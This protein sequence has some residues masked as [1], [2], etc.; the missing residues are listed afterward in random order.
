MNN[1]QLSAWFAGLFLSGLCA[2]TEPIFRLDFDSDARF[3][4][5]EKKIE[6]PESGYVK[7]KS[8]RG[9]FFERA[10]RNILPEKTAVPADPAAFRPG[11]DSRLSIRDGILFLHGKKVTVPAFKTMMRQELFY[12]TTALTASCEV[13]GAKGEQ[14]TLSVKFHPWNLPEKQKQKIR[15]K[16][17]KKH[18][19][20]ADNSVP[21]TFVMTGDWQKIAAFAELDSRTVEGRYAV[22]ELNRNGGGEPLQ[23]RN[24][25]AE[26]TMFYPHKTY[27][28]TSFLPGKTVRPPA[29]SG[30]VLSDS[31]LQQHFPMEKGTVMFWIFLPSDNR[32][33]RN[34][35]AFFGFARGW[36]YPMW[37]LRSNGGTTGLKTGVFLKKGFP[38]NRWVHAALVW[39]QNQSYLYL[40][41]KPAISSPRKKFPKSNPDKYQLTIGRTQ[42]PHECADA[43]LD[44]FMIFDQAL[45]ESEIAAF[46]SERIQKPTSSHRFKVKPFSVPPFFRD[47]PKAGILLTVES[48]KNCRITAEITSFETARHVFQ[49]NKGTNEI[50]LPFHPARMSPGKGKLKIILRGPEGIFLVYH[51]SYEIHPAVRRDLMRVLSWGGYRPVPLHYLK[52]LGINAV[53]TTPEKELEEATRLGMLVNLDFRNH[54]EMVQ[55]NFDL[56]KTLAST[57]DGIRKMRGRYNW[58]GT[59]LNSEAYMSWNNFPMWK[60]TSP[61]LY[62]RAEQAMGTLGDLRRVKVSPHM[63]DPAEL[64]PAPDS[65]GIYEKPGPG[66][67]FLNWY[68][69]EGVPV[70]GLNRAD[71]RCAAET[72]PDNLIWVEPPFSAG[73]FRGMGMGGV[74]V[75]LVTLQEVAGKL[76]REWATIQNG[77]C[78]RIQ[79]TLTMYYW[80]N[81]KE[82]AVCNGK[83]Y[84]LIRS[85]DQL[86][87][88]CWAAAGAVG[89]HD[90]CFFNVYAWYD[91]EKTH[92][93]Y[94]PFSNLSRPFGKFFREEFYPAALLLRDTAEPPAEIAL[95]LPSD[96]AV[97]SEKSWNLY[98]TTCMW[99]RNLALHN[100]HF[101]VLSGDSAHQRN[102]ESYR[103]LILPMLKYVS[104]SLHQRLSVMSGKTRI[105]TDLDCRQTYP[106]MLRLDYKHNPGR[107]YDQNTFRNII[108]F[109]KELEAQG[110]GRSFRAVGTTGPVMYFER[111]HNGVRFLLVINNHW[112]S[113]FITE[114]AVDKKPRG[115]PLQPTGIAQT[116]HVT[117]NQAENCVIYDFKTGKQIPFKTRG[118]QAWFETELEPGN[119]RLF[120]V[121]PA[122]FSKLT[123]QSSGKPEKG[124]VFPFTLTMLDR[125]GNT[126]PGRQII[127]AVIKDGKGRSTDETGWYVMEAG[128]L[129]IPIRIGLDA[130]SGKWTISIREQT[131]S[132]NAESTF[133]LP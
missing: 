105:V 18:P 51:S 103:I 104:R 97:Y 65:Q 111:I 114:C 126:L 116:A 85:L 32:L 89:M 64:D 117:V 112:K 69:N 62:Q 90:L 127:R 11:P 110:T 50:F 77:G 38:Q 13:R 42:W 5:F 91:A 86:K 25:Q 10:S 113:D 34:G 94:L 83:N 123:L 40:D 70:I 43:I 48:E 107:P 7:G 2:A 101:D 58:Y 100:I 132:L 78:K 28:P 44:E 67:R 8:G 1:K 93:D 102:P 72:D 52:S 27:A 59:L 19:L 130:P 120:C 37:N 6:L 46:A 12:E 4:N 74:W 23:I 125:K 106:G 39:D 121:Y 45:S 26:Q 14:V 66:Y 84:L 76:R 124:K 31:W 57:A 109:L 88:N 15:D 122:P 30:L 128:R 80:I 17:K 73:Q 35:G 21:A 133:S 108:P 49:L 29:G 54:K 129:T 53:N 131:S 9:Y 33:K 24:L 119:A 98:R 20:K 55:N 60:E 41:G 71:A 118:Q 96:A 75:Y 95:Y 56:E 79:P 81:D 82:K 61:I 63:V 99:E 3:G 87:S 115:F 16:A 92:R 22:I 68:K 36:H 47:D